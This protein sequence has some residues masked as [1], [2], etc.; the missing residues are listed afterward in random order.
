MTHTE[1]FGHDKITGKSGRDC[2]IC[3]KARAEAWYRAN[4]EKTIVRSAAWAAANPEKRRAIG[5]R[6]YHACPEKSR[7]WGRAHT[8][9]VRAIKK[10]YRAA[11]ADKLR[12]IRRAWIAANPEKH[13][14]R[15][16]AYRK[17]HVDQFR[18]YTRCRRARKRN[19]KGVHTAADVAAQFTAQRGRCYWCGKKVGK[20][21]DVDHV[22][23][24]S[25]GGS[26][27]PDNIVIACP[28]C[29]RT[30]HN[31]M[32]EVFAGRLL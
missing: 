9:E 30:K 6:F 31:Q 23:P 18:A 21:Y 27:G 25:R 5:R 4:R 11:N 24:L 10:A 28:H 29:N 13:R 19:A 16:V 32:P 20:K 17:A 7:E 2:K 14:A 22:I 15:K 12:A 8:E 3:M 1:R 26:N